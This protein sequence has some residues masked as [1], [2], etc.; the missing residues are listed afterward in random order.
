MYTPYICNSLPWCNCNLAHVH[1]EAQSK[2]PHW[3]GTTNLQTDSVTSHKG[4][5][6]CCWLPY[7]TCSL[8]DSP[9]QA[10]VPFPSLS[11]AYAPHFP[12]CCGA[13]P[14]HLLL[15]SS[16]ELSPLPACSEPSSLPSFSGSCCSSPPVH[17]YYFSCYYS[18]RG[19]LPYLFCF[20]P[21]SL[22]SCCHA[23]WCTF[24]RSL[25]SFSVSLF[26]VSSF[27]DKHHWDHHKRWCKE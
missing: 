16:A 11:C 3:Q 8:S 5:S 26:F 13:Y 27:H 24:P 2:G 10:Q 9:T 21:C 15:L 23:P 6:C 7:G 17:D 22:L 18:W 12:N 19:P 14:E 25:F 1:A 4:G 20:C